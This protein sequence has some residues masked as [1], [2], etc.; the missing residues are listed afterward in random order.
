MRCGLPLA[1]YILTFQLHMQV[2]VL[3]FFRNSPYIVSDRVSATSYQHP[4]DTK[5]PQQDCDIAHLV[6][7]RSFCQR[8]EFFMHSHLPI[9]ARCIS[10]YRDVHDVQV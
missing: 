2:L 8:Y 9:A 4:W 5:I 3:A 6:P 10:L 7:P 1:T